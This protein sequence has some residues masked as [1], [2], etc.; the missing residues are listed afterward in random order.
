M[1]SIAFSPV[2]I[3]ASSDF[4]SNKTSLEDAVYK[5][6]LNTEKSKNIKKKSVED[7]FV[8]K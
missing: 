2:S 8:K 6:W 4:E 3:G 5:T 1:V 7:F